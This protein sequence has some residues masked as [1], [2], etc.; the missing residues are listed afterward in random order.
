MN[1]KTVLKQISMMG[2]QFYPK[3]D[4]LLKHK[5]YEKE[6]IKSGSNDNGSLNRIKEQILKSRKLIE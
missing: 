4:D 3:V 5:K 1:D 6:E 2:N